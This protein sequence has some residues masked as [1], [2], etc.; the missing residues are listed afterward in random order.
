MGKKDL[1]MGMLV[2]AGALLLER[3]MSYPSSPNIFIQFFCLLIPAINHNHAFDKEVPLAGFHFH[4]QLQLPQYK[5][6][7]PL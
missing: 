7:L 1:F 3:R 2:G 6:C 4:S 5:Y